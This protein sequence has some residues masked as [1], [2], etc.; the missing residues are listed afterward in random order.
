VNAV[1]TTASFV[2]TRG[3]VIT[4][5]MSTTSS[6]VQLNTYQIIMLADNH[7]SFMIIN[8]QNFQINQSTTQNF[9]GGASSQYNN[10]LC[11]FTGA[12]LVYL[13][14]VTSALP[15][16]SCLTYFFNFS[17]AY[18]NDTSVSLNGS[19]TAPVNFGFA[20]QYAGAVFTYATICNGNLLLN[21]STLN[22]ISTT[23][24]LS[25]NTV[26]TGSVFYRTETSLAGLAVLNSLIN[27]AFPSLIPSFSATQAFV[28]TWYHV[29]VNGVAG[30]EASFQTILIADPYHS[31]FINAFGS[32]TSYSNSSYTMNG[33]V[34]NYAGSPTTSNVGTSGYFV[35]QV[36]SSPYPGR[37]PLYY[38]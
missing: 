35:Y 21:G 28:A 31:Y 29:N 27:G 7:R 36:S 24:N 5:Y 34:N 18:T 3:F 20:F 16:L 37:V 15:D 1:Y 4:Y 13:V 33:T 14:S 8:V 26:I 25:L 17:T 19:C 11:L 23:Q 9:Y 6:P 2:A 22:Q 30:A 38:I 32:I 10:Q 12:R